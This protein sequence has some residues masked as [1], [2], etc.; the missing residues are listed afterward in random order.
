MLHIHTN[1]KT[2]GGSWRTTGGNAW[3]LQLEHKL[4]VMASR[5]VIRRSLAAVMLASADR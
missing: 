2:A 1:Q 3:P 5:A 4:T